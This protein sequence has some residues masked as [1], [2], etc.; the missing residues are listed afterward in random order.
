MGWW[1]TRW[2]LART[3]PARTGRWAAGEL[4]CAALTWA[5]LAWVVGL[6][7]A[8]AVSGGVPAWSTGVWLTLLLA[9]AL[10]YGTNFLAVR[11]LFQPREPIGPPLGW[12]WRQGL[13][14]AR[15]AE[16]AQ[17]VGEIVEARL[18]TPA[19]LAAELSRVVQQDHALD[20]LGDQVVRALSEREDLGRELARGLTAEPGRRSAVEA[21]A[22]AVGQ[23][24][25]EPRV[26]AVVGEALRRWLSTSSPQVIAQVRRVVKRAT[27]ESQVQTWARK[28][29]LDWEQVERAF[30]DELQRDK[31]R[32]WA[33]GLVEGLAPLLDTV[34]DEV[35]TEATALQLVSQEA[36][37]SDPLRRA[38]RDALLPAVREEVVAWI[39]GGGLTGALEGLE[40]GR[41]VAEAAAGLRVEEL[42]AMAEEV[43][44]QHLGA[45]QVLGYVLGLL[46][47][48]VLAGIE[49]L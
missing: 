5:T 35:W 11:M 30:V 48:V 38:V 34:V 26:R 25:H 19:R 36:A 49:A 24:L 6:G 7:L 39:R 20:R 44:A 42:E 3:A 41:L 4:L 18:L 9:G 15:Q 46:A 23:R 28:N 47:G 40:V 22:R 27:R 29:L 17:R 45:I 12:V 1:R 32:A 43:A 8:R 14:P 16:L 33:E 31:G 13:I 10:G 2:R 37:Q 21:L